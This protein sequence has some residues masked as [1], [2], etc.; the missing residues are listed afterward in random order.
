LR[1][2][3]L[4]ALADSSDWSKNTYNNTISLLRRAF[5]FG[6]RDYPEKHNPTLSLASAHM[7]RRDRG[8]IDP[9]TIQEAETLIASIHYEWGEAQ[10]NYDEF[11]F[12]KGLRPSEQI[13]PVLDDKAAVSSD[14]ALAT[15]TGVP[16]ARIDWD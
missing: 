10:G 15:T 5:K 6:D 13:A 11:R 4:V 8:T 2:S 7:T 1:H 16:S 14:L 3:T 12:F 9:F